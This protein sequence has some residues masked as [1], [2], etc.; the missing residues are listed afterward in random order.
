MAEDLNNT[1]INDIVNNKN[2]KDNSESD[3][4][5]QE[6]F[7]GKKV[8]GLLED[9]YNSINEEH[10]EIKDLMDNITGLVTDGEAD[11]G[12]LGFIGPVLS[13]LLDVSVKNNEQYIKL[14]EVVQKYLK[15][16]VKNKRIEAKQNDNTS[17]A[18]ISLSESDKEKLKEVKNKTN[19]IREATDKIQQ[20]LDQKGLIDG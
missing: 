9:I 15:I 16:D 2:K 12:M 7:Q 8:N 14:A 5:Q 17:D 3:A 1:N 10:T 19:N 13:D 20:E 18:K 11:E 4:L 6:V